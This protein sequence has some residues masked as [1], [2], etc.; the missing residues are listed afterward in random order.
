MEEEPKAWNCALRNM[1]VMV[2]QKDLPRIQRSIQKGRRSQELETRRG[3][4]RL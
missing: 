2:K 4:Y 3:V 1:L